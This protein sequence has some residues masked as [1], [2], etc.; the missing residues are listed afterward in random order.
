MKNIPNYTKKI[1]LLTVM[2]IICCCINDSKSNTVVGNAQRIINVG[3][4]EM[5]QANFMVDCDK[6]VLTMRST[7]YSDNGLNNRKEHSHSIQ[8]DGSH[9]SDKFDY[10]PVYNTSGN[11]SNSS[12]I[13]SDL[14]FKYLQR[15][16]CSYFENICGGLDTADKNARDYQPVSEVHDEV[17]PSNNC[18]GKVVATSYK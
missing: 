14:L 11:T 12:N 13:D 4:T 3:S 7:C 17:L 9:P 10:L 6:S 8:P 18:Q 16:S 2:T 5:V 1:S 15:K